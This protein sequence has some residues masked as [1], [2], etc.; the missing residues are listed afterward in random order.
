MAADVFVVSDIHAG[1]AAG[2][3]ML[4]EAG[5]DLLED[6]SEWVALKQ[7]QGGATSVHLVING[8]VVDFLAEEPFEAFSGEDSAVTKFQR[9]VA[10][11]QPVWAQWKRLVERGGRVT[12]LL[13]NH[14]IEL[15][16]PKVQAVLQDALGD[17]RVEFLFDNRALVLG[18]VLIEHGNRYDSWNRV[19]HDELR[20]VRSALSRG[21][22]APE[23]T[24][25]P[26]NELVV[27]VVNEVKKHVDFIDLLK[28]EREGMLPLLTVLAPTRAG[29]ALKFLGQYSRTW[30]NSVDEQGQPKRPG[31]IKGKVPGSA[32][33]LVSDEVWNLCKQLR[34]STATIS[35]KAGDDWIERWDSLSRKNQDKNLE[36]MRRALEKH[37]SANQEA[38]NAD[39]EEEDYLLPA[40]EAIRRGFQLVIYGH[41]HLVRRVE[42]G[43]RRYLNSGTWA[44]LMR[45]PKNVFGDDREK[46]IGELR[47]MI[48]DLVDGRS[49][50]LRFQY[51]TFVWIPE[52]KPEL[53]DVHVYHGNGRHDP[54]PAGN[55]PH[56][57]SEGPSA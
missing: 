5:A 24:I 36:K 23:F 43:D 46:A 38:F 44:D 32:D 15:T 6:F 31:Y 49:A 8:D 35:K 51:P 33:R 30:F 40:T 37:E 18:H 55:R 21:E 56:P 17:G 48:E 9:I 14:D 7:R 28:P 53:A 2:F 29:K 50:K 11:T 47:S 12:V 52:G 45:F 34:G 54:V 41:T 19:Q 1:G 4:S 3:R 39:V 16:Y 42:F 10:A 57:N 27:Q 20:Q 22:K 26:G 25:Q 13:G